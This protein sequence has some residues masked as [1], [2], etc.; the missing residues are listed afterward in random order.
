MFAA[1]QSNIQRW[2]AV[3]LSAA[4]LQTVMMIVQYVQGGKSGSILACVIVSC[5]FLFFYAVY[6]RTLWRGQAASLTR[7]KWFLLLHLVVSTWYVWV[8][9]ITYLF[10]AAGYQI[11]ALLFDADGSNDLL[12]GPR[13]L[14]TALF[15]LTLLSSLS[16]VLLIRAHSV[17]LPL[18]LAASRGA[19]HL[20][21]TFAVVTDVVVAVLSGVSYGMQRDWGTIVL[22]ILALLALAVDARAA[23]AAWKWD[24]VHGDWHMQCQLLAVQHTLLVSTV[25]LVNFALLLLYSVG[26]SI[27]SIISSST[28]GGAQILVTI[29]TYAAM[30]VTS[31]VLVGMH[32]S[33]EAESGGAHALP[34]SAVAGGAYHYGQLDNA[35]A[36]PV[37]L[38]GAGGSAQALAVPLPLGAAAVP[39]GDI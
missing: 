25:F 15:V 38:A 20:H 29:V 9:L 37:P 10:H 14:V 35:A 30:L 34:P 17:R 32:L 7:A 3:G 13:R 5:A 4:L 6:A 18:G 21:W 16:D 36:V 26:L 39:L 11:F 19:V 8:A 22:I 12:P 33:A 27:P 2:A 31:C 24:Q 1:T 23:V 28:T